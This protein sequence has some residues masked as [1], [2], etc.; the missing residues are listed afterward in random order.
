MQLTDIGIPPADAKARLDEYTSLI[1]EER[2]TEDDAIAAGYRAAARGQQV[3]SLT[4]AFATA[5][6]FE[7]GLPRLGIARADDET[8]FVR[9]SGENL[10]FADHDRWDANRGAL[11]GV[12]SVRVPIAD[13]PVLPKG[14]YRSWS[15]GKTIV[16]I[17]PPRFRP[18]RRRRLHRLH[19]LWE[20]LK[21]TP[22]PPEDPALLR[23]IRGDLWAVLATWDLTALERAVLAQRASTG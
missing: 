23:H 7:N 9:W 14:K 10:V 16:P 13:P 15:A 11:V 8:C 5:G 12:H 17:V 21:W 18:R 3:I 6:Y 20:V 1:Y 4:Q 2:T 19:V 22:V